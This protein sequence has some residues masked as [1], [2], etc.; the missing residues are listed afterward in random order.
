MN[1][2]ETLHSALQ[3]YQS[4]DI[5]RAESLMKKLVKQQP[6]NPYIL[7]FLGIMNA[8]LEKYDGAIQYLQRSLQLNAANPDANL[9][10][11][12]LFLRDGKL[13]EATTYF[14]KTLEL[15]PESFE[16]LEYLANICIT[17][18]QFN[19]A[20]AY[21]YN[22]LQRKPN[23]ADMYVKLGFSLQ[24]Q[25]LLKDAL[26]YYQKALQLNPSLLQA[27]N[28]IGAIFVK[29]EKS[30]EAIIYFQK[31][32]RINPFLHDIYLNMG[33]ALYNQGSNEEALMA[34]DMAI[35]LNPDFIAAHF[36]RC[37]SQVKIFYPD[38][39]SI[40]I[41]RKRYHEELQKLHETILCDFPHKSESAESA[42]GSSQP[43]FLAYQACND[44]ELQQL[45]GGL[46]CRIMQARYPQFS[47]RCV[48]P[49]CTPG[50]PLRIG[51]VSSFFHSH[52]NWKIPIRGWIE[53]MN[54]GKFSLYGYYTGTIKDAT[55]EAARTHFHRF[56]EN[57]YSFEDLCDVI[58]ND[59]LHV[60][61]YPAI[62]MDQL[63]IKLAALRLAPVQCVSWG[64]PDTTGLPTIDYYLSS[65]LMEPADADFHYTEQLIRLP[66]LSVHYTPL[67]IPVASANRDT[68]GIRKN[69]VLYLCCQNL[70]KYLPQYDAIYPRIA[71][72]VGDCQFIFL[73][74]RRS[75]S[76]TGEFHSRIKRAF[77][78]CDMDGDYHLVFLPTLDPAHY[79]A[80][81]CMADV[82][83]DSIGWSGCNS[84]LEAVSCNVP[85]VTLPGEFMRSRHSSAILTMM[86]LRHTIASTLDEYVD[87]AV[88]LGLEPEWRKQLS[89]QVRA[90][91][92]LVYRDTVC[93]NALEE[94]L[95]KVV[96]ER[97]S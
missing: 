96:Q 22:A 46:V 14:K 68:Y 11:G 26:Q 92:H 40:A 84:T 17:K 77:D 78:E 87:I 56:V 31:A 20:I 3:Y 64:H 37:M 18:K 57:L 93:I 8:Q 72:K 30:D 42:V 21:C 75:S 59:N 16:A 81:N 27:Y 60:L 23:H 6:E 39:P 55:T 47:T 41:S 38:Q 52:S 71:Q 50:T 89:D 12:S 5:V 48:M 33:Q 35:F 43:F 2:Q 80:L 9:A 82:Y 74:F 44:R 69:S 61:I 85:V 97:Q 83:L 94:F 90:R 4:G 7:F 91:K 24:E 86:G 76:V 15:N 36:A 63:T 28:N 95:E 19:E 29:I 51:I 25:G 70:C 34:Y 66:N 10:L 58:A 73:A 67:D 62:N 53:N 32:L 88:R 49:P 13:E 65:D 79:L 1:P 54:K 45:Y